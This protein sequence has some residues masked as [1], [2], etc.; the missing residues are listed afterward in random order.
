MC[1]MTHYIILNLISNW[2]K[3]QCLPNDRMKLHLD[4]EVHNIFHVMF[5]L[6]RT[7]YLLIRILINPMDDC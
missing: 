2:G 1:F 4:S 6:V 3:E 5:I 7:F